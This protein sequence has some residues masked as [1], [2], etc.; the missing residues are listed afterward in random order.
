MGTDDGPAD[1]RDDAGSGLPG[2]VRI[3]AQCL[4]VTGETPTGRQMVCCP[5]CAASE[6]LTLVARYRNAHVEC[7][8]GHQWHEPHFTATVVRALMHRVNTGADTSQVVSGPAVMMLPVLDEP[9][10]LAA[11]PPSGSEDDDSPLAALA[12]ERASEQF[13]ADLANHDCAARSCFRMARQMLCLGLPADGNL[14]SRLYPR[15]GGNAVDA[16]MSVVVLALALYE[17]VLATSRGTGTGA[18]LATVPFETV[19]EQLSPG[20]AVQ[21]RACR[22]RLMHSRFYF[23]RSRDLGRLESASDEAFERW[24]RAADDVLAFTAS[25][26]AQSSMWHRWQEQDDCPFDLRFADSVVPSFPDDYEWYWSG[27]A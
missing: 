1:P 18:A 7:P 6:P 17:A 10:D 5:T 14:Y 19:A 9:T 26:A 4:D 22:P 15:A 2:E 27:P 23:L 16:H 24:R 21:L 11:E 13:A 20:S 12:S 3:T 8:N 25:V